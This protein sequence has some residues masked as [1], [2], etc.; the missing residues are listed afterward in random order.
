[1]HRDGA[2][3]YADEVQPAFAAE[4]ADQRVPVEV[5]AG[6]DQEEIQA[7]GDRLERRAV[8]R[9]DDLVRAQALGFFLLV[10]RRGEGGDFATPGVEKAQGQMT[11]AADADHAD[12]VGG[13]DVELQQRAEHRRAGAEQRADQARVEP[14]RQRHGPGPVAAQA[15]GETAVAADYGRFYRAAELVRAFHAGVAVHAAA[16]VPAD[17]DPLAEFEAAHLLAEADDAADH[18]VAGDERVAGVAPFV[19]DHRLVGVADAAVFHGHLDLFAAQRAGVIAVRF[20]GRAG[21][22]GGPAG[23]GVEYGI[24]GVHAGSLGMQNTTLPA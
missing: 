17:P 8:G 24:G 4:G 19:V 2:R 5:G 12:L 18:L 11:Q 16:L 9:G 10:Q 1:M 7:A 20:E 6:G 3:Y 14:I 15:V 13:L 23:E 22:L 21:R